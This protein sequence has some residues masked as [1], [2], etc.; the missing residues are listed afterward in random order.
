VVGIDI[1][2]ISR[3]K[4]FLSYGER[5]YSKYLNEDEIEIAKKSINS[6]AGLWAAKEAISK[7]LKSGITKDLTFHDIHIFKHKN[8]APDFFIP[9][10]QLLEKSVSITHDGDYAAAIAFIKLRPLIN[11]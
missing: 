3:F 7:A 4:R 11:N 10:L 2:L 8:G 5:A 9:K 6:A 1:V